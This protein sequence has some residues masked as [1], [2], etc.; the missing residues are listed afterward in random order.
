MSATKGKSFSS[1]CK[2]TW[3]RRAQF[4]QLCSGEV[5]PPARCN[6]TGAGLA[7]GRSQ[8]FLDTSVLSVPSGSFRRRVSS[9]AE[10]AKAASTRSGGKS[11]MS[12]MRR[13]RGGVRGGPSPSRGSAQRRGGDYL[14]LRAEIFATQQEYP[15]G[16]LIALTDPSV[17]RTSQGKFQQDQNPESSS[18]TEPA[19]S[20]GSGQ[21]GACRRSACSTRAAGNRISTVGHVGMK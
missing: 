19:P 9:P 6:I 7:G 11:L 10:M 17:R 1:F 18:G 16:T 14:E 21:A 20:A 2:E 4:L 15:V 12:S 8:T 5:V 3:K 13:S